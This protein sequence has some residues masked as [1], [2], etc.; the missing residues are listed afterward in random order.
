[1]SRTRVALW[2]V[3]LVLAGLLATGATALAQDA[4]PVGG[5]EDHPAHIHSGTCDQLGEV[6]Y[7][8]NDVMTYTVDRSF[9]ISPAASP[10]AGEAA[11]SPVVSITSTTPVQ[12]SFTHV[13]DAN[14]TDLI[15]G[16]YAV[17]THES[18]ANIQNY[19]ACGE[20]PTC[21]G[22]ACPAVTAVVVPLSELNNSGY[23]G[24]ANIEANPNGGVDV[25]V[26]LFKKSDFTA[27]S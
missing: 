9:S 15:G 11:P 25:T 17:N 10:T 5:G 1:M 16:G 3:V 6:V 12:F 18:P 2:T 19:I 20:I 26:F 14:I 24:V 22:I 4:T 13:D 7:P 21:T 8:L 23:V 27:S